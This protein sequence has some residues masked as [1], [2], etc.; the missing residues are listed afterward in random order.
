MPD[1]SG[2]WTINREHG[3]SARAA[4]RAQNPLNDPYCLE[5][6]MKQKIVTVEID[7][8]VEGEI[9]LE[10][11]R[12]EIEAA[13]SVSNQELLDKLDLEYQRF[14]REAAITLMFEELSSYTGKVYS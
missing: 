12:E 3:D 10:D 9:N 11:Y 8:T 7:A 5:E 4:I 6:S 14:G 1:K 13:F 2:G